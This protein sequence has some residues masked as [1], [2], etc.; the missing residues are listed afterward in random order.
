MSK[1]Q[2][3]KN[4]CNSS[5]LNIQK[6]NQLKKALLLLA[7]IS[8]TKTAFSQTVPLDSI[9]NYED[10]TITVCATVESVYVSKGEKK[11]NY[12]NFGKPFPNQTLTAVIFESDLPNFKYTPSEYL[13]N[14]KV[15]ITGN[16]KMYKNK[17]QIIL[18]TVKQIEV[19]TN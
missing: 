4:S 2:F 6:T 14:K 15:C 11:T 10:K 12:I 5:S 19:E 18:N 17:P 7:I 3:N 8:L 9:A 16:V 13:T 1:K